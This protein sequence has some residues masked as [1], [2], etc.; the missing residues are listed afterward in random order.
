VT[1]CLH[2]VTW[3]VT[4]TYSQHLASKYPSCCVSF[5][6]FYNDTIVP[7]AKCACGCEHKTCVQYVDDLDH[8]HLRPCRPAQA[9]S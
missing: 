4:C 5:S 6:S 8:S 1:I 9:A 7:C 3:N 2:A